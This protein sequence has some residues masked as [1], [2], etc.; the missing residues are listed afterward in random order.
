M[1]AAAEQGPP[2]QSRAGFNG[3]G[4]SVGA[5]GRTAG[6]GE[7]AGTSS[8]GVDRKSAAASSGSR[9]RLL[10]EG[11]LTKLRGTMKNRS[12][13]FVLTSKKL[14]YYEENGG[15]QISSIQLKDI[16]GVTEIGDR[17][18]RLSTAEPFGVC[19]V[20]VLQ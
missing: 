17:K 18:F 14:M 5:A 15:P 16:M 2:P 6:G 12:R 7:V 8:R 11:A 13:W 4:G 19:D 9:E 3:G 10:C 20:G 1:A